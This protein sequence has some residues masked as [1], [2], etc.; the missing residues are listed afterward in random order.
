MSVPLPPL[1]LRDIHLPDPIHWWP[2]ALGWWILISIILMFLIIFYGI[3]YR[4]KG[5]QLRKISLIMLDSIESDYKI[6]KNVYRLTGELSALLRRVSLA[7]SERR[8]KLALQN[9]N[10]AGLTGE[11]WL[12]FLERDFPNKP[13]SQGAGKVLIWVP[14]QRDDEKMATLLEGKMD[15]LLVLCRSWLMAMP[16]SWPRRKQP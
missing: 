10:I 2:P 14:F 3:I 6:H 12:R 16:Q 4:I 7:L 15:D 13:F 5:N 1:V 8:V 9:E 11:A